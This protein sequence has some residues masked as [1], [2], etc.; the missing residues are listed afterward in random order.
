MKL[1][2][3]LDELIEKIRLMPDS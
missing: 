2:K 1:N 3:T